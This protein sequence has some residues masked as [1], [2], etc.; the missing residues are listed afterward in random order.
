M[1]GNWAF[2]ASACLVIWMISSFLN[3]QFISAKKLQPFPAGVPVSG[4]RKEWFA[5]IRASM[6]QLTA[7]VST[8]LDGYQK[9]SNYMY[10]EMAS[11][12]FPF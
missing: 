9:V 5:L 7:G 2:Y 10:L 4:M 12:F 1:L 11:F 6:R 3:S 8:L